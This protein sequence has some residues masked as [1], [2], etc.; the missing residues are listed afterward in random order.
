MA[1]RPFPILPGVIKLKESAIRVYLDGDPA[2]LTTI[3]EG[4]RFR[5]DDYWRSEAYQLFKGT[6]GERGWD[7]YFYPIKRVPQTNNRGLGL[8]GYLNDVTSFCEVHHIKYD[9]AEC[10]VSP[11]KG[12]TVDDI[13]DD[14][15]QAPFHLDF[16]QRQCIAS[17]L[18]HG[19]GVHHIS[20]AG[21]KT[22]CFAAAA[23]LILQRFPTAR[24]LYFTPTERLVRQAYSDLKKFL[25][26]RSISQYGGGKR[27]NTGR[28]IVVATNAILWRNYKDLIRAGWFK[29]FMGICFDE[30]HHACA[31]SAEKVLLEIPAYFRMG[32]SD[33]KKESDQV[34]HTKIVGLLGPWLETIEPGELIDAGRA[35]KP[36][37]YIVD[38]REWKDKFIDLDHTARPDTDAWVLIE[39]TWRRG[40]YVGPVYELFTAKAVKVAK[41][42]GIDLDP[43]CL[44]N[45]AEVLQAC[46]NL[47]VE[48]ATVQNIHRIQVE[49]EVLELNSRWCLLHRLYDKAIIRFKARNE[50]I[51][52]WAAYY[53]AKGYPTLVVA[54]RTLHVYV[55]ESV[56]KECGVNPELVRVLFSEHSSKE[57]D[58]TF[59]WFRRTK[60]AIMVTPLV[61]EGVSINELRAGIIADPVADFEV[62]K[63]IIGRFIRVKKGDNRCEITWF[64]DRQHPTFRRNGMKLFRYLETVRGFEFYYPLRG[65]DTISLATR[66]EASSL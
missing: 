19:N 38:V 63:Q 59:S 18:E 10:L 2:E 1:G 56:I 17:W 34:R 16:S 44:N 27:D 26:G 61:K 62:A 7:G 24:L 13:P 57:R 55:L 30:C 51:G 6:N 36:T 14:V 48:P 53:S 23:S 43:V 46:K 8:R 4:L 32:A 54:T 20:V 33:T 39:N 22:V 42:A 15:V 45:S 29:T 50:L 31:P 41:D 65:P 35:A 3:I 28:H 9:T 66:F 11:F 37:I 60:G 47:G 58:D 5:P 12:I 40:V 52:A 64:M 25:P 21:G 49:G